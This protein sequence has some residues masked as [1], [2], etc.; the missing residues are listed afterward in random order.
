M[1]SMSA[2][3]GLNPGITSASSVTVGL[4]G[5]VHQT[6]TSGS[7]DG[8]SISRCDRSKVHSQRAGHR[9]V[10][11]VMVIPVDRQEPTNNVR[12]GSEAG[13]AEPAPV[14]RYWLESG[15]RWSVLNWI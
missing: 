15:L 2:G 11:R 5:G 4:A 13:I 6:R 3:V 7:N 1:N 8:C 10:P 9:R 14:V 12:Y